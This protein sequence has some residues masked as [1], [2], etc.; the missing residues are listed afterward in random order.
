[1]QLFRTRLINTY[2]III[3]IISVII[4]NR[5]KH[6]ICLCNVHHRRVIAFADVRK[7]T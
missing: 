2:I 1:M 5:I 7:L 6:L 4:I 3:I